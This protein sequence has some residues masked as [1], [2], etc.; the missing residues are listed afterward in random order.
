MAMITDYDCWKIEEE[1][2]SAQAIFGHL[3]ANAETARRILADALPRIPGTPDW[4]EH[5][6]LA[7]ALTT[8]RG[9]WPERTID[10]LRPI[11][12]PYL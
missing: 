7:A 11:L 10:K 5:S 1:P 2:V 8:E 6:A 4:E 9:L 12:G 3:T